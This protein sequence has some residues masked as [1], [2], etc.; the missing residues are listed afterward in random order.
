MDPKNFQQLEQ[1]LYAALKHSPEERRDFAAK[2]CAGNEALRNK[3]ESLLEAH[4]QADGLL[5]PPPL[6]ATTDDES[7]G[8]FADNFPGTLLGAYKLLRQIG[9]GGMGVVYHAQQLQPIR[10]DV[11][12]KVIKP[13]MDTKEVIARFESE[14]QAL[15]LM[16]HPAIAK[17]FEAGVTPQGR[18]YF[19]MEYVPGDAL[20]PYCTRH[21]LSIH[22]RLELFLQVCDGV[23]HA[24]QKGIIH[25]DLKPSNILVTVLNTRPVPKIIDFGVAKAVTQPL[26]DRTLQTQL[27][28]LIGTPEYMSPE[29][30]E[31]TG[32]DVDTRTDVY[33][34]GVIL[35]ELLTGALPFDA[36]MLRQKSLDE[37]RRL[38]REM[39]PPRPSSRVAFATT[40]IPSESRRSDAPLARDLRGD[41]DWITMR[42]L[43]KDRTHRYATVSELA[44]DIQRH[45][46]HEPVLAG[47]PSTI[48]RV[49]KF[50]RRH[51]IGVA[52]VSAIMAALIVGVIGTSIGWI[53]TRDAHRAAAQQAQVAEQ[54]SEF[55]VG[56]FQISDPSQSRG[57]DVTAREILDVGA[58]RI[59][60]Q[61]REQP[62][63]QAT[64]MMTMGRVYKNLGLYDSA[65]ALVQNALEF[66]TMLLGKNHPLVFDSISQL[67]AI[68]RDKG[69]FAKAQPLF[70]TALDGRRQ[71]LGPRHEDVGASLN[72]LGTLKF[73]QGKYA[74]AEPLFREALEIRRDRLGEEH[75]QTM[76]SLN[77]LAMT[78]Q[79]AKNTPAAALPMLTRVLEV[80]RKVLGNNHPDVAQ[81]LN[82]LAMAHYRLKEYA[83]AEPLFREALEMNRRFFGPEHPEVSTTLNNLALARRDQGDYAEADA[84]FREVLQIDRKVRGPEHPYVA[85]T[86]QNLAAVRA[87][88]RDEAG[89]EVL[90]REALSLHRKVFGEEAWQTANTKSMLGESLFKLGRRKEAEPLLIEAVPIL[91]KQL[92]LDHPAARAARERLAALNSRR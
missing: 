30:A 81:S 18:P 64:L 90:L 74:E 4:A 24:H 54:V 40:T 47:P 27:G 55:L 53:R 28:A 65:A 61:L 29:Q 59:R 21:R 3:L 84:L 43:A 80:R 22:D 36:Q 11:A 14:R 66:R 13:G 57:N 48:Y 72:D 31:M 67:A 33:A 71:L 78:V 2:A 44:S 69:D 83:A 87:R 73:E 5:A 42:A 38:I 35:Y 6:D 16:G 15:A 1:L 49:R 34:L 68:W 86:I 85:D 70:L 19:A 88:A 50:V 77:D 17:V 23:Q 39:D 51:R 89:A 26:T 37:I 62:L 32:L 63:V 41:L 25:R 75:L 9:E 76:E 92:G 82:N 7:E 20:V 56:L 46:R 91:E 58:D 52:A 12:I 79:R 60:G 45:L 8:K 10:R